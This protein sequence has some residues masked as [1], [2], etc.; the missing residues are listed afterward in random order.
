MRFRGWRQTVLG[1]LGGTG[2]ALLCGA[3]HDPFDL[4]ADGHDYDLSAGLLDEETRVYYFDLFVAIATKCA[5][6]DWESYVEAI[7]S[8]GRN[9]YALVRAETLYDDTAAVLPFVSVTWDGSSATALSLPIT[10]AA[11][12]ER[13]ILLEVT[14]QDTVD[15]SLEAE[16]TGFDGSNVAFTPAGESRGLAL[17][18]SISD[19]ATTRIP[20]TIR[21]G[22]TTST[23]TLPVNMVQ[24]ARIVG[25]AWDGDAGQARP[26]RVAVFGGDNEHRHGEKYEGVPVLSEG[27]IP[28]GL[29]NNYLRH[30]FYS[31]GSFELNVPPGDVSIVMER[32]FEFDVETLDITLA[33]GEVRNVTLSSSRFVTMRDANWISGETHTHW[34]WGALFENQDIDLLGLVQQ[35]EDIQ[36]V[37]NLTLRHYNSGQGVEFVR[38]D[39][40]PMGPVPGYATPP[41]VIQM[42]Q[43]FRND[44]FYGHLCFLNLTNRIV[45]RGIGRA[46]SVVTGLVQPISTGDL[47]GPFSEDYPV[48]YTRIDRALAQRPPESRPLIVCAH[49]MKGEVPADV[50]L[51]RVDSIDQVRPIDY[52]R[53]LDCGFRIA[54]T[55]GTDFPAGHVGRTRCYS[56]VQPPFTFGAWIDG[57]I[58]GATFA[59]SGP[60]L[61]MT[62]NGQ[63][64]GSEVS[65]SS[66][67]TVSIHVEAH[68]RVPIGS[69][70]IMSNNGLLHDQSYGGT[71]AVV[72]IDI[73]ADESRWIIARC[74]A[75]PSPMYRPFSEKNAAHTSATYLIVDGEDIYVDSGASQYLRNL[76]EQGGDDVYTNGLF[77]EPGA[78]A[79][80][81]E[82]RDYFYSGRDV[83]QALIDANP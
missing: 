53:F 42:G 41:Y 58:A 29:G 51:G 64:I 26:A 38:P 40:A 12:V 45:S 48:N 9:T 24:P 62:V 2:L 37:N 47:V 7:S 74:S 72:D 13:S 81:T 34:V 30:Y 70:Q 82:A 63:D 17:R 79:K 22:Q 35:A 65:V 19:L 4:C 14:N 20:I 77:Y 55:D 11:G 18:F 56:K 27:R 16:I 57:V 28:N 31:D 80:R 61:W 46:A 33:P 10:F 25:S 68:S 43:E 75:E 36:V 67:A 52:Y 23:I 39:H 44:P 83:Y 78:E 49:G 76:C 69:L 5:L 15:H 66:G 3:A 8:L 73:T 32:G 60:M 54:M 6:E 71:S 21:S 1:A 59:T 50:A